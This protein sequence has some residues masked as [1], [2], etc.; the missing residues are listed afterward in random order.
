MTFVLV[1]GGP[2]GV[3]L[4]GALGEIARDTLKRDFRSIHPGEARVVLVELSPR[5]LMSFPEGRSARTSAM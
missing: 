1:G 4:A 5:I 3:E 2:T